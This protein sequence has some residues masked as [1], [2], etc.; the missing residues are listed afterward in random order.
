MK[1]YI[2]QYKQ[3]CSKLTDG[4]TKK[5]IRSYNKTITEL[6]ALEKEIRQLDEETVISIAEILLDDPEPRVRVHAAAFC[7]TAGLRVHKQKAMAV[8][9]SVN[10]K[11]YP[12]DTWGLVAHFMFCI[13]MGEYDF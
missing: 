6:N 10:R 9:N 3:L 5:A 13:R 7:V 8:F 2:H 4:T 12:S 11:D 1:Q